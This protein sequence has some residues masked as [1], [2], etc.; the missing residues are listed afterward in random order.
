MRLNPISQLKYRLSAAIDWRVSQEFDKEREL[1]RQT[2]KSVV[3]AST[4]YV[5]QIAALT[6]TIEH[7]EQRLQELEN[8]IT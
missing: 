5:D 6:R 7:L 4:A 2:N 3:D 8:K 1:I